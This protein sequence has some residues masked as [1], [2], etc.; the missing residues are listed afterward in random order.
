MAID[1]EMRHLVAKALKARPKKENY[2]TSIYCSDVFCNQAL[3]GW[4][5]KIRKNGAMMLPVMCAKGPKMRFLQSKLA[6]AYP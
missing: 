3:R 4:R 1:E 5:G 2:T 6:C